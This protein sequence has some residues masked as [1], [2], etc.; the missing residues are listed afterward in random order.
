MHKRIACF[1]IGLSI[2]TT[3]S[4]WSATNAIDFATQAGSIAGAAAA[5]GQNLN[6]FMQRAQEALNLLALND[7]DKATA[8]QAF[9]QNLLNMQTRQSQKPPIPCSQVLQEYA[10]LPLLQD[11]YK[12]TVLP[13]LTTADPTIP[14]T[15]APTT[16]LPFSTTTSTQSYISNTPTTDTKNLAPSS[17]AIPDSNGI[18]ETPTP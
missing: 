3:A 17:T 13:K 18:I 16:T 6:I 10:S 15:T 4:A 14:A 5:C 9:Q 1:T 12:T 7:L 2:F 11:D 8:T